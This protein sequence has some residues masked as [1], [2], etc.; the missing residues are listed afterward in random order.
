[1]KLIQRVKQEI[2]RRNY[3]YSTE[4]SYCN[5]IERYVRFHQLK[6]PELMGNKEIVQFLNHLA[7]ERHV[8]AST[9]NLALCA[10]VFLYQ[11]VLKKNIGELEHLKRAKKPDH[12]D[13]GII[14]KDVEKSYQKSKESSQSGSCPGVWPDYSS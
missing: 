7:L 3:S 5:W 8:A 12:H 13:A 9:Q 14:G 1:M 6:H 4:K 11:E 2:R 10:I